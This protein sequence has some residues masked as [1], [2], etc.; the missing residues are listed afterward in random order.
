MSPALDGARI[1]LVTASASRL[2]GGVFEAVVSHAAMLRDLGAAPHVFAL[3]DAYVARD[4]ARF[5]PTPVTPCHVA[6]PAQIG[7]SPQLDRVLADAALD[8]LHLHGIWM[9]PSAAASRWAKRTKRAYLISPHGMLDPWITARGQRKKALARWAYERRSWA[10]ATAFHALTDDEASD[11]RDESGRSDI[12]VIPNAAPPAS[13][14]PRTAVPGP[15]VVYIGRIHPKKNLI[16]LI[17]GWNAAS[18]PNGATL[19]IAGWGDDESVRSV[20]S[21]IAQGDG[22]VEFAGPVFGEAKQE[23]L[24]R[25]RFVVL[26]SLSEGLP[27]A[28]L[29]AWARGLPTI[30][31]AHCHLPVGFSAGAALECGTKAAAIAG[32][33]EGA[34]RMDDDGWR[35]MA[36]AATTCARTHFSTETISA[37]WADFYASAMKAPLAGNS[38][39]R[40]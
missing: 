40:T 4:M 7:F 22:T 2:G 23:L 14:P 34:L 11:I 38:H 20:R 27:V 5:A 15:R 18:K 30:M 37:A 8:C 6:G 35:R 28:V 21:A 3:S 19:T 33:L 16:A 29:E 32:A 10:R 31:T 1:G 25:A 24:D 12:R 36:A 39:V 17:A 26:P 9:Y 13:L